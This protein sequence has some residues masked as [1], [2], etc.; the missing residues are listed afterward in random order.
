MIAD[1]QIPVRSEKAT[2]A[3]RRPFAYPGSVCE[4][5]WNA[6]L[7]APSES[8]DSRCSADGSQDGHHRRLEPTV[9]PGT[10]AVA[11]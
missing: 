9:S 4:D 5:P 8:G 11:D 7:S 10:D 1:R 2:L 6:S 3:D